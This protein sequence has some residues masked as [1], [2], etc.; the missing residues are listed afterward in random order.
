MYSIY[1]LRDDLVW[2][3]TESPY[4]FLLRDL[5]FSASDGRP[6]Q[7]PGYVA[8]VSSDLNHTKMCKSNKCHCVV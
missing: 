4:Y 8:I 1:L 6:N 2:V 5:H 3:G 7:T